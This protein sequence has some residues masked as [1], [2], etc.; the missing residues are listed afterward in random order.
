MN[1]T[2]IH[3]VIGGGESGIGF[4]PCR[5]DW[6]VTLRDLCEQQKV[7]FFWKQWGGRTPKSGGRLLD[8]EEWSEYPAQLLAV[9]LAF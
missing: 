5:E 3:W 9:E 6:A 4:R 8:G 2:D 1:L 7:A